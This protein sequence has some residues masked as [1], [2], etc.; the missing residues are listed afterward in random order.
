MIV[1]ITRIRNEENIIQNTLDHVAKLVDKIYVYDDCSTDNTVAICEAHPVVEKV[2]KGTT[3][4]STPKGRNIA[5]GALRQIV[6]E[7]AVKGG[8]TWVYYFDADEYVEFNYVGF[9]VDSYSFRLFDFYITEEDKEKS[10]LERKWMGPEYRDIPMLFRVKPGIK[11]TQRIPQGIGR[12]ELGGFVKHYGKAISVEQWE[13]ACNYY[14]NLRWNMPR[15]KALQQRW[16]NRKG[17]AIHTV[18][19]FGG[20]LIQWKDKNKHRKICRMS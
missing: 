5:E 17:K 2:I 3:W 18:S 10:Y 11:F 15:Y 6:Y 12:S 16:L 19:D 7:E 20:K 4:A 14:G 8:A 1:G 13:E 9:N